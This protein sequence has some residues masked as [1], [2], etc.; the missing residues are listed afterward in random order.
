MVK[1]AAPTAKERKACWDARDEYWQC[2]DANN[3]DAS[4]CQKLRH[5]FTNNCPQQWMKYFDKRRDYLKYKE[6]LQG[7]STTETTEK[8]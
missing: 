5:G 6:K 8:S 3:E 7:G 1:M 2:L 4:K